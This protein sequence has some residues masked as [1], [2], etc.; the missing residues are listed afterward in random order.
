MSL[1]RLLELAGNPEK[2]LRCRPSKVAHAPGGE[3]GRPVC[4]YA[5]EPK[6][7]NGAWFG[8]DGWSLV[9]PEAY[10]EGMLRA[11]RMCLTVLEG[12]GWPP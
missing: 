3:M 9:D 1:E 2:V 11:C 4:N 6:E 5:A 8:G 10:P 12:T 7:G